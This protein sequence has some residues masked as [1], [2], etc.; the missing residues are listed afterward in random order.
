[1]EVRATAEDRDT[2]LFE[3]HLR[4]DDAA[5]VELFNA[6]NHRLYVYCVKLVG[7]AARAEDL[8]QELWEKV[9]RMRL[10]PPSVHNPGGLFVRMARNLSLNAIRDRRRLTSLDEL[11]ESAH[12][13]EER[14][15][16]TEMEEIVESALEQLPF[17]YREVLILNA[18]SGYN[19]EEI[20]AML[21]KS[22]QAIW[23][24]ASRAREK[25]RAIVVRMSAASAARTAL[26]LGTADEA[27]EGG[28]TNQAGTPR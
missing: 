9:V 3:R 8:T 25:L 15:E 17:E 27:G 20:A 4:G 2:Q 16:K 12:P 22:P 14:R 28:Y 7:S 10:D 23:K 13:L 11:G 5:L 24:R 26:A 19:H 21:G 1:M 6:H 18:Y